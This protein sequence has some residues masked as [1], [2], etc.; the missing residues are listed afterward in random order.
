MSVAK[1]HTATHGYTNNKTETKF[2]IIREHWL[3]GEPSKLTYS[4]YLSNFNSAAVNMGMQVS[5]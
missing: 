3:K 1:T 2:V 5:L 4:R